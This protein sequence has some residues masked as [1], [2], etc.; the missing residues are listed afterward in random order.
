MPYGLPE[1]FLSL[2]FDQFDQFKDKLKIN[3]DIKNK[4]YNII[5]FPLDIKENNESVST[6]YFKP[7]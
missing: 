7:T 2:I 3:R 5:K 4:W 1:S 6:L